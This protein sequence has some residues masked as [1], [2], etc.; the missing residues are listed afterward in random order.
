MTNQILLNQARKAR[1]QAEQSN[2]PELYKRAANLF[3][4][5]GWQAAAA[6]MYDRAEYYQGLKYAVLS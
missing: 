1:A 6:R 4:M 5:L 3:D 2:D